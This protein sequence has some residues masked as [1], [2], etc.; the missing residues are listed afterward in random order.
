[1]LTALHSGLRKSELLSLT[2]HDVALRRHVVTVQT[3]YAKN[4][5]ARGVPMN[6]ILTTM[7]QAIKMTT[8]T[9]DLVFCNRNGIP[10]SPSAPRSRLQCRRPG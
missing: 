7:L 9:D 2:W 1:M 10:I 8:T 5:D 3:A 4:G 6:D